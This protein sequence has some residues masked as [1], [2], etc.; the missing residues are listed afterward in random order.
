MAEDKVLHTKLTVLTGP[1]SV[2]LWTHS[3]YQT[4]PILCPACLELL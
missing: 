1:Q 2:T 3:I 4:G